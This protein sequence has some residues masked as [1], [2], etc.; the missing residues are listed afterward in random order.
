MEVN[1]G[2]TFGNDFYNVKK[3][4][5]HNQNEVEYDPLLPRHPFFLLAVGPRHTGKSNCIVDLVINKIGISF[6]DIII[7]Y[8]KTI[9][10]DDKWD[11]ITKQIGFKTVRTSYSEEKLEQDYTTIVTI[12]EKLNPTL[13]TLFIFDD[14]I[15][16]NMSCKIKIDCLGKLATMG[17]H[18]GAS[19]LFSTQYYKSLSPVIRNNATHL[20]VFFQ[21]NGEEFDKIAKANKAHLNIK[22]FWKIYE[23]VFNGT[24]PR[25][26]TGER[27]FLQVNNTKAIHER[28]WR[29]WNQPIILEGL[30]LPENPLLNTKTNAHKNKQTLKENQDEKEFKKE[31]ALQ[32]FEEDQP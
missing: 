7:I 12:R 30:N 6:F 28:Y 22:T 20:L 10:D 1:L 8:C 11:L 14:M 2:Q 13:K 3:I 15:S 5:Q 23:S 16:E 25:T 19:V 17:R 27:P 18:K 24:D 26:G 4:P 31:I 9:M 29:C 32:A 21:S